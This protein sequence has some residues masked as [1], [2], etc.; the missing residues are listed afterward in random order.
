M[1][2]YQV[3]W[4]QH[5]RAIQEESVQAAIARYRGGEAVEALLYAAAYEVLAHLMETLDGY[6]SFCGGRMDVV[7]CQTGER[8]RGEE[9]LELHDQL[10]DYLVC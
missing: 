7:A 1:T 4:F 10:A 6:T 5:L 9:E 2:A 3:K 8:L